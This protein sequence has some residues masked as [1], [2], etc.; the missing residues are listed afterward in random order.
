MTN[1]VKEIGCSDWRLVIDLIRIHFLNREDFL[2]IKNVNGNTVITD[3]NDGH[4]L[5]IDNLKLFTED[6]WVVYGDDGKT[7]YYTFMLPSEY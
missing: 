3:G 2:S 4:L 6:V 7:Q 1:G 5:S